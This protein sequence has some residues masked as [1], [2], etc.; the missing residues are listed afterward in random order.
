MQ[1][2][3]ELTVLV[4]R[5]SSGGWEVELPGQPERIS[6]NTLEEARRAVRLVVARRQ[7]YRIVVRDA[8]L[9]VVA[10]EL[11]HEDP[12]SAPGLTPPAITA[13]TAT[14][15]TAP[16]LGVTPSGAGQKDSPVH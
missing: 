14:G 1:V 13:R 10:R 7:A 3:T 8:Y 2:A 11:I 12:E 5:A 6:C 4:N 16:A 15:R 9:R